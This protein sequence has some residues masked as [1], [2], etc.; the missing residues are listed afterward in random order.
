[1]I[2]WISSMGRFWTDETDSNHAASVRLTSAFCAARI[3]STSEEAE[4][5]IGARRTGERR[6]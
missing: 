6:E 2:A 4:G 3:S 1:M 5:N